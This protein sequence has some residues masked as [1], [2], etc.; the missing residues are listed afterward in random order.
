ML[1]ANFGFDIK[2][3]TLPATFPAF[4]CISESNDGYAALFVMAP[5]VLLD[6]RNTACISE[7]LIEA[8]SH[9]SVQVAPRHWR[10]IRV[11]V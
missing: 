7:L 10:R 1:T 9:G 8:E 11:I 5:P 2:L 3:P 4:R 6:A